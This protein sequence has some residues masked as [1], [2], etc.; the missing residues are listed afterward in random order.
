MKMNQYTPIHC[1]H[2]PPTPEIMKAWGNQFKLIAE[3]TADPGNP[4]DP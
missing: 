1:G 2:T 3:N 4:F